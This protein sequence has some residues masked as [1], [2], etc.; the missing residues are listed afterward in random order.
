MDIK[1][2]LII[3]NCTIFTP[4]DLLYHYDLLVVNKRI[5]RIGKNINWEYD[6]PITI[7]DAKDMLVSPGL[8]DSHTH[9]GNGF[10]FMTASA[11]QIQQLLKWYAENG[12]T[13]V[14]PTLSPTLT[15]DYYRCCD[16]ISEVRKKGEAGARILGIHLEG[17]YINQEKK[18]VQPV[19]NGKTPDLN[20]IK[21]FIKC[22]GNPVKI[23][24]LAPEIP[25]GLQLVDFITEKG[26]IASVG[27]S[28]ATFEETEEAIKHGLSCSTHTFNGM[29]GLHRRK[30]GVVGAVMV[31]DVVYAEIILDGFHV[32][33]GAAKVLLRSKGPDKIVLISDSMQAAGLGDGEFIRPGNRKI[34]VKEGVARLESG[35]L[36]GSVLTL[37]KAV[38]NAK[39]FLEISLPQAIQ[40]ASLNVAQSIGINDLGSVSEGYLADLIVHDEHMNISHTIIA[41]EII[42]SRQQSEK[43]SEH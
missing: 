27:H 28:N 2:A 23:V 43:V 25:G 29:S 21:N 24:T 38:I 12:V 8:I 20:E 35:N 6:D 14:F 9:G 40:M 34:F 17:P 42:Y 16:L 41:G 19:V 30:P 4:K 7:L 39:N 26:I 32:H 22:S 5:E 33:P 31:H 10:D 18:G 15:D 3:K 36:A 11:D 37:N 13:S 1:S